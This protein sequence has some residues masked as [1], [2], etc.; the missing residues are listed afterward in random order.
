MNKHILMIGGAG[1]VG[2]AIAHELSKKHYR[3]LIPTRQKKGLE[4]L[5]TNPFVEK[6]TFIKKTE[7][8]NKN[9]K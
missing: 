5:K 3:V 8:P 2:Q 1:F 6:K 9:Q 7:K 4:N